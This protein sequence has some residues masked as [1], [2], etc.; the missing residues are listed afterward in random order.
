MT[1]NIDFP[2]PVVIDITGRGRT[3]RVDAITGMTSS[4][5]QGF[6][7]QNA[8]LVTDAQAAAVDANQAAASAD[9]AVTLA[10]QAQAASLEV[11]DNNV[12]ALIGNPATL[13]AEALA[14]RFQPETGPNPLTG[15]WH[16]VD[17]LPGRAWSTD[18]ATN[19][20]AIQAAIDEAAAAGGGV[21]YLHANNGVSVPVA[22]GIQ[23]RLRVEVHGQPYLVFDDG[24]HHLEAD[25]TEPIFKCGTFTPAPLADQTTEHAAQVSLYMHAGL[26]NVSAQN[27]SGP[28]VTMHHAQ[29]FLIRNA[30]FSSTT[31]PGTVVGR[32]CYRSKI[33]G[34]SVIKYWWVP[35]GP[36]PEDTLV[37]AGFAIDLGADANGVVIDGVICGGAL[38]GGGIHV[39]RSYDVSIENVIIETSKW[40]ICLATSTDTN[41]GAGTVTA[42][43]LRNINTERTLH[44]V[45]LG[46]GSGSVRGGAWHASL[47][48]VG[49]VPLDDAS[50]WPNET[51]HPRSGMI[52][53]GRVEGMDMGG[54]DLQMAGDD[55][56]PV[57][58]TP[59]GTGE[60]L[61]DCRLWP[62]LVKDYGGTGSTIQFP[63]TVTNRITRAIN[64]TNTLP[65]PSGATTALQS[66]TTDT[67]TVT[68]GLLSRA[69]IPPR[70]YGGRIVSVDI[71]DVTG[72][73]A[74]AE[75]WLGDSLGATRF[76][77]VALGSVV[78]D[79]GYAS[80]GIS[81]GVVRDDSPAHLVIQPGTGDG[82]FRVRFQWHGAP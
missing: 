64:G 2:D 21:V 25:S 49:G 60:S 75:L 33:I 52:H 42:P 61:K 1:V 59:W 63:S 72:S 39:E 80:L 26:V 41:D 29:N 10:Q 40:G 17:R 6:L 44:P 45:T 46:T 27:R 14:A 48:S 51:N 8:Q 54:I 58:V 4:Q 22:A 81:G 34:Q 76:G 66:T 56:P 5:A 65:T 79:S 53:L 32:Y 68:E 55:M 19:T 70:P 16:A 23:L 57:L 69:V 11:P 82:T 50:L 74:G 12:S 38:F 43:S 30:Q 7:D 36:Y 71:I 35:G 18:P 31:G 20:A 77:Q 13:T 78:T 37:P 9:D 67:V 15:M 73:L 24:T 47:L 3:L 62:L 28:V